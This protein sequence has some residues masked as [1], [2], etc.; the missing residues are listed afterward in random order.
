MMLKKCI[1]FLFATSGLLFSSKILGNLTYRVEFQGVREAQLETALKAASQL[2]NSSEH[3]AASLGVL[4][5]RAE[6]D[7]INFVKVLHNLAYYN[8][9]V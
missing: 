7:V 4:K 8:A 3:S 1:F 6:A 2:E 9:N 5:R